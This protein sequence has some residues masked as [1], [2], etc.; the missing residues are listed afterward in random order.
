MSKVY[1]KDLVKKYGDIVA[2]QNLNLEVNSGEF[3]C[4][5]GPSGCG[6]TTTLRMIA[7]IEAPDSGKIY[8]S[9]KDVT[10]VKTEFRNVGLAFQFPIFYKGMSVYENI[11]VPLIGRVKKKEIKSR[12]NDIVELLNIGD[13]LK[14]KYNQLNAGLKQLI[15]LARVFIKERN[16][17]LL[18]EPLTGV[19]P[20]TRLEL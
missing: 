4:L 14:M 6:K 13:P 2:V 1:L 19:D 7:G 18:D 5:L 12:V 11:A 20:I 3:V 8:F 17:Y 15:V 10:E 9:E 16:V